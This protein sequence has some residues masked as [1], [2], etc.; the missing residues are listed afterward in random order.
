MTE[1]LKIDELLYFHHFKKFDPILLKQVEKIKK[2]VTSGPPPYVCTKKSHNSREI[3]KCCEFE[4]KRI[5]ELFE[6][7]YNIKL[8]SIAGGGSKYF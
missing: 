5:V 4:R 6:S 2:F 3:R 1:L 8:L 7:L